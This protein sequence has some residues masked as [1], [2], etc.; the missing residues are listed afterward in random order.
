MMIAVKK[1]PDAEKKS[2]I[3]TIGIQTIAVIICSYP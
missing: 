2:V 3:K 1:A